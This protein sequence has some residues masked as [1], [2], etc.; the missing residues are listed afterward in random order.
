MDNNGDHGGDSD[1]ERDSL[2]AFHR[3]GTIFLMDKCLKIVI[4]QKA[5][6]CWIK[7]S[8][9]PAEHGANYRIGWSEKE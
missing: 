2:L 9:R 5:A 3:T 8:S 6:I 7:G 1:L 4:I